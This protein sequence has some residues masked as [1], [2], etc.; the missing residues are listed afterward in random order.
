[1]VKKTRSEKPD[2]K[3]ET[4]IV[5]PTQSSR[6]QT[7]NNVAKHDSSKSSQNKKVTDHKTGNK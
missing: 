1:M 5:L 2:S 3:L 7:P 6:P 4:P